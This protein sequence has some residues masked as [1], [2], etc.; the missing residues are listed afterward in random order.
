VGW[1]RALIRRST[2]A[3]LFLAG[4]AVASGF[5]G[6][7]LP[8]SFIPEE[9][10]GYAFIQLQLPDAAS[11]QR[12]DAVMRKVDDLLAH[13]HGIQGYDAIAGYS[14]LSNTSSTYSGFYFLQFDPWE[15]RHSAELS[16]AGIVRTLNAKIK[17]TI[18]RQS[19]LLSDHQLSP[20]WE[21]PAVSLSCCRTALVE[22]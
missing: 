15:E 3:M 22:R 2:I 4:M 9:D 17:E 12:T 11:L 7:S 6:K 18:P 5:M 10:Q 14:L 16:A 20:A 1:S 8:T 21:Q 13:T 19:D